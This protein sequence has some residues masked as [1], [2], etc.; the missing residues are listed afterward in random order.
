VQKR[1]ILAL[2][3]DFDGLIVETE[4]P[5]FQSWQE[6]YQAHGQELPFSLW[7]QIIGTYENPW[8]PLTELEQ[9][10]ARPVDEALLAARL[11]RETELV[12]Q[13]GPMPGIE[14]LLEAAQKA[15]LKI[16]LASSSDREWVETHL[17]RLGLLHYFDCLRTKDDV[18]HTKPDPEL[19]LAALACLGVKPEQALVL[20]DSPMGVL[21][22]RR[23]GIFVVAVP[24]ELTRVLSFEHANLRL[25]TLEGVSLEEL[26][27]RAGR[28]GNSA[29]LPA[30]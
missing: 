27:A 10:L 19:Y 13:Q 12:S 14:A 23:A 28:N 24:N 17:S 18:R 20:E 21:A 1:E 7:S 8:H 29:N 11:Q 4:G 9:R 16:G 2:I 6:L 25:D 22:A 3:F 26:L 15:G 5:I 30:G